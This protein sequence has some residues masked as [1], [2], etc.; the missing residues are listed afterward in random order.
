MHHRSE[1]DALPS[2]LSISICEKPQSD[3]MQ[4]PSPTA[5]QLFCP[6][7]SGGL[8]LPS[9]K[10]VVSHIAAGLDQAPAYTTHQG[11]DH[12]CVAVQCICLCYL[13]TLNSDFECN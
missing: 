9:K 10:V 5:A 4:H 6:C 3:L 8:V 13:T 2:S 12:D 1:H 11:F 7:L